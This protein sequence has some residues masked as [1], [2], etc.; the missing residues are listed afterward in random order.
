MVKSIAI[1]KCYNQLYAIKI[2][3][4]GKNLWL[5]TKKTYLL[6]KNTFSKLNDNVPEFSNILPQKASQERAWIKRDGRE[7]V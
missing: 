4:E 7:T 1:E 6:Q 3:S 5:L 2:L